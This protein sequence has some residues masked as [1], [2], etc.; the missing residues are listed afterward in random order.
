MDSSPRNPSPVVQNGEKG[1]LVF[2][3]ICPVLIV[4]LSKRN[5][6]KL[7][8]LTEDRHLTTLPSTSSLLPSPGDLGAELAPSGPSLSEQDSVSIPEG[9][10]THTTLSPTSQRSS[11]L[12]KVLDVTLLNANPCSSV[13][14]VCL[15]LC[16]L[17]NF[18]FIRCI[19]GTL[20]GLYWQSG[21]GEIHHESH[22]CQL[23]AWQQLQ[24]H[25]IPIV[26][27]AFPLDQ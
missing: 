24:P 16:L 5:P 20:A 18:Y 22:P 9:T 25:S 17:F 27:D 4:F 10:H 12:E 7:I 15:V 23:P 6:S 14:S 2:S 3:W 1:E 19:W 8:V 21:E 11:S 26:S 13:C